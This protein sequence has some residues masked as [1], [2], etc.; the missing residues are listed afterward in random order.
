MKPSKTNLK[1]RDAII[2]DDVTASGGTPVKA[3]DLVKKHNPRR[4]FI[5][6]PHL[7]SR[8]GIEKIYNLRVDEIIT[9]DSF[10]SEEPK[11]FIELTLVPLVSNYIKKL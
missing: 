1:D 8:E 11:G 2:Y 3:F 10:I 7:V 6:L 9:T 4:I 5:A